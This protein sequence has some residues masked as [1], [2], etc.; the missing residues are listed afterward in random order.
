MGDAKGE[1]KKL[2]LNGKL[3][4]QV[5]Q[6]GDVR[7]DAEAG[8]E[9]LKSK[10]LYK[11][12]SKAQVMYHQARSFAEV[13]K[14]LY[15]SNRH[16]QS[17]RNTDV[18]PFVV[19]TCF[20]LEVYLKGIIELVDGGSPKGHD[21]LKI[22]EKLPEK[23]Q[24]Q[25]E[26]KFSGV[27]KEDGPV[28]TLSIRECLKQHQNAFVDWRYLYETDFVDKVSVGNVVALAMTMDEVFLN[29]YKEKGAG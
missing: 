22:F 28:E 7:A 23:I 25:L 14:R 27:V 3:V 13:S 20:A 5:L 10:G 4:G 12:S 19:N 2:Y 26:A 24:N 9:L 1:Y 6:T 21:L 16:L 8:I 18:A 11:K 17:W 29:I 15:Q